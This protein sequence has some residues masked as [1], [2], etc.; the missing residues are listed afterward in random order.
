VMEQ[1]IDLVEHLR[2]ETAPSPS[3]VPRQ[4]E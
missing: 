2:G 4:L 3:G 1:L